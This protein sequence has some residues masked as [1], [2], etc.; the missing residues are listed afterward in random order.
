MKKIKKGQVWFVDLKH[1][2]SNI[3]HGAHPVVVLGN[4]MANTYSPVVTVVVM[5]SFKGKKGIPTHVLVKND[6]LKKDSIEIG[7]A[8]CRERV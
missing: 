3:T 8:A 4:W 7:R 2:Y 6:F 5:T 1:T